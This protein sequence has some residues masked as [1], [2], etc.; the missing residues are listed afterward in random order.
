MSLELR[1]DRWNMDVTGTPP[2]WM[3]YGCQWNSAQIDEIWMSM[4]LCPDRWNMDV[5][6]TPPR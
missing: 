1:P 2:R 6:G 5:N 4:E 3:E